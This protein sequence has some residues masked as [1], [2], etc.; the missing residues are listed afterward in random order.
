MEKVLKVFADVG[1][2]LVL[3]PNISSTCERNRKWSTQIETR[4]I[5]FYDSDLGHCC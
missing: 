1:I 4:K 2:L 5:G 3:Q